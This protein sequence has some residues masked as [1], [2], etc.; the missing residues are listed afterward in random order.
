VVFWEYDGKEINYEVHL[1]HVVVRFLFIT[2]PYPSWRLCSARVRSYAREKCLV[3]EFRA[4][5]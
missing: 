4:H 3:L 5:K 1:H 2:L